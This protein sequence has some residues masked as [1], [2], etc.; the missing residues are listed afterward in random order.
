MTDSTSA[1]AY[2][3]TANKE[4]LIKR[5]HRIEGQVRG[6]EKMLAHDRYRID[7]IRGCRARTRFSFLRGCGGPARD[8]VAQPGPTG[9]AH[10]GF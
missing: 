5:M 10:N 8:A 7:I 9:S 3:Y 2:G 1:P 6:I 4:A